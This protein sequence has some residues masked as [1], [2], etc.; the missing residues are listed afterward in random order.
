MGRPVNGPWQTTT[1]HVDGR[2]RSACFTYP[3]RTPV[4]EVAAGNTV[5]K[6][7]LH[8]NRIDDASV[9][10]AREL[11]NQARTFAEEVERLHQGLTMRQIRLHQAQGGTA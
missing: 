3:H 4:F 6:V 1:L 7:T 9:T 8:A 2:G 11:A 10:F 5:M